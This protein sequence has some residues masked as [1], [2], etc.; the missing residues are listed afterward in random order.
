MDA[1]VQGALLI[2]K[3]F[4]PRVLL[5]KDLRVFPFNFSQATLNRILWWQRSLS[6][7]ILLIKLT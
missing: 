4:V 6:T 3:L 7:I 1:V 2:F 5:S